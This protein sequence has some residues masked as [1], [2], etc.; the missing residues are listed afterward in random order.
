M[1]YHWGGE[2]ER[3]EMNWRNFITVD[4]EIAHGQACFKGTRVLASVVLDN[5]A[6]GLSAEEILKS[7]PSLSREAIQ[8]AIA[9]G[10]ELAR[11]HIVAMPV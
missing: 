5:L 2:I 7:Y 10:A 4:P 3:F 1:G 11:E 9:Y 6:A 8:A